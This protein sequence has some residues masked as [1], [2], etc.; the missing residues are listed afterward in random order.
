[1]SEQIFYCKCGCGEEVKKDGGLKRKHS[2]AWKKQQDTQED[3]QEDTQKQ[4]DLPPEEPIRQISIVS[5]NEYPPTD[6]DMRA[7]FLIDDVP[8][9]VSKPLNYYGIT[10]DGSTGIQM[11]SVFILTD[12]GLFLPPSTIEGF[13]G[14]FPG[15]Q[16]FSS[17]EESEETSIE[18]LPENEGKELLRNVVN[19]IK[20]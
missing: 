20:D 5:I 8:V 6:E 19:E 3:T 10:L 16:E 14:L 13:I 11:A 17:L 9:P 12:E 4:N 18:A 1:M 7:W 15:T 2:D